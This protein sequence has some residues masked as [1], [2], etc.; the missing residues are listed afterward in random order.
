MDAEPVSRLSPEQQAA[1][2]DEL[3]AVFAMLTGVDQE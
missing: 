3:K 1:L 2:S